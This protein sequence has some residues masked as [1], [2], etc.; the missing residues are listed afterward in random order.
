M[1][2][3]NRTAVVTGATSGLGEQ[4]TLALAKQGWRVLAVGRDAERGA[5]VAAKAPGK[6]EFVSADLFSLADVK[7][8]AK[9]IARV[10]P[11]LELLLASAFTIAADISARADNSADFPPSQSIWLASALLQLVR[12][13]ALRSIFTT[14]IALARRLPYLLHHTINLKGEGIKDYAHNRKKTDG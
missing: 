13:R 10:A 9:E 8:L 7:R 12:L 14:R 2:K 11:K 5:Q 4:A 1:A 3:L 6:I